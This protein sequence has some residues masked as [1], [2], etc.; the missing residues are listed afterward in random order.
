MYIN[1]GYLNNSR[2][3][4]KDN[5]T[6]L[7]VGSCGT[8]RLKTRP[9]LPTYW[10]KGRRDYQILYVANGKTHFW[11]DGKEEI[12]SAGHM[13]LYKPEE[14][15]KYVYY[16]EDNPEVFWIHFTGSDVKNI[17]AYH[18]ISLDEHVFY[19]GVLPDYK[20]LFRKIIQELQLCRYGYEDYIA[21]LFND[22][23][24]LVDRQQHEQKKAT[25][26]VQEQ[27]ERA[28]A[29]FNE[30]YNTKISIDDYAESL[31]ISTNWFI[32]NF[33]QYAGMSPAQYILSLRMVN[34]QS[35]LER[36][37]YNIKEISEIVGY[38]NPLYFSR[39]FKKEIGKSPA[40]YRKEAAF[41]DRKYKKFKFHLICAMR[42]LIAG[43][44]VV[45]GQARQQQ[46][47]C[48]KL[49][50]VVKNDADMK[51]MLDAAVTCLD[52]ACSECPDIP[53]SEQHRS[54]EI[55]VAMI[56]V[57]ERQTKAAKDNAFLKK[58]DIVHCT[59]TAIKPYSVDVIIKTD[60]ARNCGS[61]YISRIAKQYIEDIHDFMSIG[62]IFQAKIINDNFY[63]KPWGWELSKIF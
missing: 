52:S 1:S 59:V 23:L 38:E 18:G 11:F 10:Q 36:T 12:V 34:A 27:I 49:W 22:I 21:S 55:T 29:Y 39:V 4:F 33:K 48:K 58:G 35:L 53:V 26:N 24:L 42:T 7:V 54:K 14:I 5:S 13:V 2:T 40:Q 44:A 45:F 41:L 32:H 56:S 9:K 62:Q 47:I 57:A 15:Q 16:L 20:A 17:L 43:S 60:D 6:P 63:E 19:C 8:Y 51:R 3:D 30:N 50:E 25:G 46:K 28:A 37:T 61:I 31:H